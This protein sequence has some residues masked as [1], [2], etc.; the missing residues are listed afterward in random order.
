[1]PETPKRISVIRRYR[2]L[3]FIVPVAIIHII[4]GQH[5]LN[6]RKPFHLFPSANRSVISTTQNTEAGMAS[7]LWFQN[8]SYKAEISYVLSKDPLHNQ[9]GTR[10]RAGLIF[11][12]PDRSFIDLSNYEK[13]NLNLF[14]KESK[15]VEIVLRIF[16]PNFTTLGNEMTY[17]HL[18]YYLPVTT[19]LTRF[20]IPLSRFDIPE[21]WLTINKLSR[22]DSV[23]N[24]DL[25]KVQDIVLTNDEKHP[26]DINSKI[27][28]TSIWFSPKDWDYNKLLF[29]LLPIYLIITVFFVAKYKRVLSKPGL[30]NIFF[31]KIQIQ[32]RNQPDP[33]FLIDYIKNNSSESNL[34]L[35][36]IS[37]ATLFPEKKISVIVKEK[38]GMNFS[39]YLKHLRIEK[40]KELLLNS[41]DKIIDIAFNSGYNTINNFNFYFKEATG[42]TPKQFRKVYKNKNG[43]KTY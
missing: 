1:M 23:I 4:L 43:N 36:T 18:K 16:L 2:L 14:T 41:D 15:S 30:N 35:G 11:S 31:K 37:S 3:L 21:W 7:I 26:F 33:D 25:S 22:Y 34:S 32:S 13:I 9:E 20:S 17:L 27:S 6:Y 19:N 8:N 38:T 40:A 5:F 24:V 29:F 10:P 42:T 12:N 28:V 39:D